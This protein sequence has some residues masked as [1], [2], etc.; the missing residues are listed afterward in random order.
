ME[1]VEGLEWCEEVVGDLE[2]TVVAFEQC[3]GSTKSEVVVRSWLTM[4]AKLRVRADF[5]LETL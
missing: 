5:G 2:A 3:A 1:R 4:E